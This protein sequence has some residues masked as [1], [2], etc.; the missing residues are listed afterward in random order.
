MYAALVLELGLERA[1]YAA[2]V[3]E[4]Y[5]RVDGKCEKAVQ[6]ALAEFVD[7]LDRYDMKE[8]S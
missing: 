5:T 4:R 6:R 2:L 7:R 3:L 1:T 8:A